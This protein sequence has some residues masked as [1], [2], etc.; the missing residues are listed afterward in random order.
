M[1]V[2]HVFSGITANGGT[3]NLENMKSIGFSKTQSADNYITDSAAGGTALACGQK[4]N[5]GAI[6]VDKNGNKITSILELGEQHGKATGL[7]ST[8]SIT[9]ATPASFMLMWPNDPA[10]KIL[11]SIS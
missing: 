1:G 4:T 10:M 6:G 11:P 5:N 8:S 3:L 9:H 7:V 2:A